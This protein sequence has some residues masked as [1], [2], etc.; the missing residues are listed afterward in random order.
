MSR[1]HL[2]GILAIFCAWPGVVKGQNGGIQCDPPCERGTCLT[3]FRFFTGCICDE[4]FD[5]QSC[6]T[7]IM[8][9]DLECPDNLH[10]PTYHGKNF[11]FVTFEPIRMSDNAGPELELYLSPKS[12]SAFYYGENDVE[13]KAVDNSGNE[14]TCSFTIYVQDEESPV[15]ECPPNITY[16]LGNGE[17]DM[18]VN[19]SA[20]SVTDNVD[21]SV[22]VTSSPR[23]GSEF[24]LGVHLVEMEAVDKSG[25]IGRC[26]FTVTILDLFVCEDGSLLEKDAEC[27]SLWDCP[28]G[29]E[30]YNC[31]P[32]TANET[33][34]H[35][36][37]NQNG[38]WKFRV[39]EGF[40]IH[41]KIRS[42]SYGRVTVGEGNVPWEYILHEDSNLNIIYE[43]SNLTA[44]LDIFL[45]TNTIWMIYQSGSYDDEEDLI[46]IFIDS[47]AITSPIHIE[48][49]NFILRND[50][51]YN[52]LS[53]VYLWR[54]TV[55]VDKWLTG[56]FLE[57]ER[58]VDLLIRKSE[59]HT[60]F[61]LGRSHDFIYP[62]EEIWIK[63]DGIR[64]FSLNLSALT[65]QVIQVP[66]VDKHIVS[67]Y[68]SLTSPCSLENWIIE[69]PQPFQ[70]AMKFLNTNV[71]QR[72]RR[73]LFYEGDLSNMT[74]VGKLFPT[75]DVVENSFVT[76]LTKGMVG[77]VF[78]PLAFCQYE[79]TV[80]NQTFLDL[81]F[82]LENLTVKLE[83][84]EVFQMTSLRESY[85][86]D[87]FFN[88][89]I[90]TSNKELFVEV[91]LPFL[92]CSS[93][94]NGPLAMSFASLESPHPFTSSITTS[95]S[96]DLGVLRTVALDSTIE[97]R[98]PYNI[99]IHSSVP[100]VGYMVCPES[101]VV[102]R[103]DQ[104]C[105]TVLD[106]PTH[107]DEIGCEPTYVDINTTAELLIPAV[108]SQ[109]IIYSFQ[110]NNSDD[111]FLFQYD[112]SRNDIIVVSGS[113]PYLGS[114]SSPSTT[115]QQK[116]I[117][118]K[119]QLI[120]TEN[121]IW[122]KI[123]S[124]AHK[125]VFFGTL[126]VAGV[127][128]Y[129]D[130]GNNL[131]VSN[132]YKCDGLHHCSN[133][134]DETDCAPLLENQGTDLSL[135]TSFQETT[136][137]SFSKET[138]TF[139]EIDLNNYASRS[140]YMAV[141]TGSYYSENSSTIIEWNPHE[142]TD[143]IIITFYDKIWIVMKARFSL[144]SSSP[145]SVTA[146]SVNDY[147]YCGNN[148]VVSI[149]YKCDGLHH[150][151]N[152]FDEKDCSPLLENQE[153]DLSLPTSFQETTVW[154]FSKVAESFFEI[155]LDNYASRSYYMAVGTGSYYSENSSTII[156][157]NPYESTDRII[158]TLYD[159]IWI[160]MKASSSLPSSSPGSVTAHGFNEVNTEITSEASSFVYPT[161]T[162]SNR[163]YHWVYRFPPGMGGKVHCD[164]IALRS[165]QTMEIG[166]VEEN[167]FLPAIVVLRNQYS[168][169]TAEIQIP[170]EV[171]WIKVNYT[172]SS[173]RSYRF[174][175]FVCAVNTTVKL[176][177]GEPSEVVYVGEDDKLIWIGW[178]IQTP[179]M[180][181]TYFA[182]GNEDLSDVTVGVG[183]NVEKNV[184]SDYLFHLSAKTRNF[185]IN[186][187][188]WTYLSTDRCRYRC[189]WSY[190]I[191]AAHLE[192][193]FLCAES[194][195]VLNSTVV[196]DGTPDCPY[197]DDEIGCEIAGD[198]IATFFTTEYPDNIP[199]GR[200]Q[201]WEYHTQK[202]N[203]TVIVHFRELFLGYSDNFYAGVGELSPENSSVNYRPAADCIL[204]RYDP[205]Q[206]LY[207]QSNMIWVVIESSSNSESGK[208]WA[209]VRA[210]H[211]S[212]DIL[213]C[214][215]GRHIAVKDQIC[216]NLWTC[217]NGE[218]EVGCNAVQIFEEDDAFS[219]EFS[220]TI[221]VIESTYSW[222]FASNTNE[223]VFAVTLTTDNLN[224]FQL[225]IG[226]GIDFLDIT[227][228]QKVFYSPHKSD[229]TY[230]LG[231]EIWLLLEGTLANEVINITVVPNSE[232]QVCEGSGTLITSEKICNNNWD[233]ED[234][235]DEFYCEVNVTMDTTLEVSSQ[236]YP[237]R[238]NNVLNR[239][240]IYVFPEG[241]GGLLQCDD[242][243]LAY[244]QTLEFGTGE[245][246]FQLNGT[247]AVLRDHY[248]Y[249]TA[250]IQIPS[251]T[252]WIKF[253]Y[254]SSYSS[255]FY[256][257]H[258]SV[259][260]VDAT[261]TL[262]AGERM[263]ITYRVED[264]EF[265]WIGWNIE[266]PQLY[267]TFFSFEDEDLSQANVGVGINFEENITAAYLRQSSS[268]NSNIVTN[269]SAWTYL[270]TY[271]CS[272]RYSSCYWSYTISAVQPQEL[273]FCEGSSQP[274]HNDDVCNNV[275]DCED[276]SD[277]A[278]CEVNITS[279]E[280]Q[281]VM[282]PNYPLRSSSKL[283]RSW[284]YRF[285]A[286]MGGHLQCD[287]ISLDYGHTLEIGIGDKLFQPDGT[288][289][290][291]RDHYTYDTAEIQIPSEIVWIKF[292]YGTSS[293][294]RY[295]SFHCT[296]S[297]VS[298]TLTVG[299][300][301]SVDI[302]YRA[303]HEE[304]VWIGWNIDTPQLHFTTF[305]FGNEDLSQVTVGVGFDFNSNITAAHL[306]Q[307]SSVNMDITINGSAW[308]YLSTSR[309]NNGRY[310]YYSYY[311]SPC[312]WSY[313]VMAV[314][315]Q[316]RHFCEGSYQLINSDDLCNNAWDCE[317]GYD[318]ANCGVNVTTNGTIPEVSSPGYPIRS[319]DAQDRSWT[320]RFPATM[321]GLIECD[322][323][324]LAY[325]QTLEI[326][327][328]EN[329][330]QMNG[331][332]AV[333]R[334]SFSYDKAEI[335]IP[336]ETVWIKFNYGSRS[337]YRRY[338]SF[339]CS[340]S[341]VNA[342]V[343][344][345]PN[346][347]SEITYVAEDD[348]FVW[349]GWNIQ[350][351][352]T[353][354]TYLSVGDEDLSVITIGLGS[355]FGRNV[356]ADYILQS[357][358][359][360]QDLA[361]TGLT[362][363]YLST[364]RC[365]LYRCE[366]SYFVSAVN[367]A[368][369]FSCRES[370]VLLKT[371]LLCN[372]VPNC[373]Y[374]DDEI[375]CE[376]TEDEFVTLFSTGYPD[377]RPS[378]IMQKWEYHTKEENVTMIVH[379]RELFLG[380]SDTFY[381]GVGELSPEDSSVDYRPAQ[382]CILTRYDPIQDLYLQSNMIWIVI[383]S[384]SLSGSGKLWAEIRVVK[385]NEEILR[386]NDA[387]H[388]AANDQIC[389][390]LWT[391]EGGEDEI[392][393]DATILS[394]WETFSIEFENT[395]ESPDSN[396][397]SWSFASN[398]TESA[399]TIS[400]V[401]NRFSDLQLTIG[402]G[403]NVL[404]TTSVLRV[405]R[406]SQNLHVTYALSR[407]MWIRL[408]GMPTYETINITVIPISELYFCEGSE[409][410][411]SRDKLCD[412]AW[413]CDSGSDESF[414]ELN[415]TAGET[416][417]VFSPE[418]PLRT[419]DNRTRSWRYR[420]PDGMGGLVHCDD[421][422]LAYGQSL[423]IG[424]GERFL[425]SDGTVIELRDHYSYNT[426]KIQIPSESVWI[427]FNYGTSYYSRYYR[428][429]CSVSAVSST[430]SLELEETFEITYEAQNDEYV[431]IG[432]S[433]QVPEPLS[434]FFELDNKDLSDVTV[435][436]GIDFE[437]NI[438]ANHLFQASSY[439]RDLL[440]NGS[441]WTFL[442]T[443]SC[444]TYKCEWSYT[445]GA[446]NAKELYRCEEYDR[447][448]IPTSLCDGIWDCESGSDEYGCS[449]NILNE[450][451]NYGF[452]LS[453]PYRHNAT[454]SWIFDVP[455]GMEASLQ[456]RAVTMHRA[457]I[458]I[459]SGSNSSDLKTR[460][461]ASIDDVEKL[462]LTI[463]A[464]QLWIKTVVTE[465][466]FILE[467]LVEI[468]PVLPQDGLCSDDEFRCLYTRECIE[469][470][471]MCDGNFDCGDRSDESICDCFSPTEVRNGVGECVP[472]WSLCGG[473]SYITGA[474]SVDEMIN[475]D[476]HCTTRQPGLTVV[477]N[478]FICDG[479]YDCV[480][481]ADER[482][483]NCGC[484]LPAFSCGEKCLL[485]N[486]VCNGVIDCEDGE[487]E[488]DC[489]CS[490]FE[491]SCA[492]DCFAYWDGC[493]QERCMDIE[494]CRACPP[495]FFQCKDYTCLPAEN[496]CD[497]VGDC[498]DA[499]DEEGCSFTDVRT[500]R[501]VGGSRQNEGRVEVF[502]DGEWGTVC[503]DWWGYS[504]AAV[505]CRQLGFGD[506][507]IAYSYARFGRGEGP[508]WLDNVACTGSELRLED[509]LSNGWGI[510]NC[511]H[512]SD[513]G[514]RC[515]LDMPTVRLADGSSAYEG[516][517]EVFYQGVWG[518]VCDDDWDD[519]DATVI[520]RHLGLGDS[521]QAITFAEFGRGIGPIWMDNVNCEGHEDDIE[522]CSSNGWGDHNCGHHEDAGVICTHELTTPQDDQLSTSFT[523]LSTVQKDNQVLTDFVEV[524]TVQ[525][526]KQE[527]EF[528]TVLIGETSFPN[529]TDKTEVLDTA[530]L[531]VSTLQPD[532]QSPTDSTERSDVFT[533]EIDN[534]ASTDFKVFL[535]ETSVPIVEDETG[536]ANT[537]SPNTEDP[538]SIATQRYSDDF[539]TTEIPQMIPDTPVTILSPGYPTSLPKFTNGTWMISAPP[540][541]GIQVEVLDV[542]IGHLS[543]L[544]LGVG[545]VVDRNVIAE[546]NEYSGPV[547]HTFLLRSSNIWLK[548]LSRYRTTTKRGFFLKVTPVDGIGIRE[549]FSLMENKTIT[550]EST[551]YPGNYPVMVDD[552]WNFEVAENV[553]FTVKFVDISLE[554]NWD[555]LSVGP[556]KE[557]SFSL[558]LLKVTGET[559]PNDQVLNTRNM[560][561]RFTSDLSN[562]SRGF[563]L[564][565][566]ATGLM[567][568]PTGPTDA[569]ASADPTGSPT[570]APP[571]ANAP[572]SPTD[573]P[574]TA[575]APGI[576][577]V[578]GNSENE[579][580]V[581][582]YHNGIWG[583]VCDDSWDDNDAAVVC[584]ELG[585]EGNAE[586]VSFAEF[587]QGTGQIWLD[588][589]FCIG[590][591]SRLEDCG[592]AG[593][594]IHNC[595]HSED[596][597]V[598]CQD[599][600]DASPFTI[601]EGAIRIVGGSSSYEGRVEIFHNGIWGTICDDLWSSNDAQ[602]VCRQLG[603]TGSG[604]TRTSGFTNGYGQIW[605]T[606]VG[607]RGSET[608]LEYCSK[609]DW[610][611]NSCYH[612]ED[613]GVRCYGEIGATSNLPRAVRLVGGSDENEGRVEIF[614]NGV[615]GT[616]CDDY[617][618]SYD[619][620]VVCKQLGYGNNGEAVNFARFGRGT[621]PI[622]LDDVSCTGY[623]TRLEDCGSRG[624]G[625]HN[626]D[627][628]DDA[629]VR[630]EGGDYN[631]T[632]NSSRT[633]SYNR[634][635]SGYVEVNWNF[636]APENN[637]I[638]ISLS[639]VDIDDSE[640]EILAYLPGKTDAL[641]ITRYGV[642]SSPNVQHVKASR[643]TM[644]YTSAY[645]S[646][647]DSFT[648]ILTAVP[649]E[650][651]QCDGAE[652]PL[653]VRCDGRID[654]SEGIDELN[655]TFDRAYNE[656]EGSI[657]SDYLVKING[658]RGMT[659]GGTLINSR[660][661]LT[662]AGC[663]T[664]H[665]TSEYEVVVGVN[666][667]PRTVPENETYSVI[668]EVDISSQS[669]NE[670]GLA[671]LKLDRPVEGFGTNV[672]P[673][674][675]P[676]S[677]RNVDPGTYVNIVGWYSASPGDDVEALVTV[678]REPVV[679]EDFCMSRRYPSFSAGGVFCT[680]Y[681]QSYGADCFNIYGGPVVHDRGDGRGQEI[682]GVVV[683]QATSWEC[684]QLFAPK[685][686][687]LVSSQVDCIK[688]I[689]SNV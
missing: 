158:F 91:N 487:D 443:Y 508:I 135:P 214:T 515:E 373:P 160:V 209:E 184:T 599:M 60:L 412:Y 210:V 136:V 494:V 201:K 203:V 607:C 479:F 405:F 331:T 454:Y 447:V 43:D 401:G 153:I 400:P 631:L 445:I 344:L 419:S 98:C 204:T 655:C 559:I 155:N 233:C 365:Y 343:T 19:F 303:E 342:T 275:W 499:E 281:E 461:F 29:E 619:A 228:V 143:R 629:G 554:N 621:G 142:S 249:D 104:T 337:S 78:F 444:N 463:P 582:I 114:R 88:R 425:Q 276:G 298:T 396:E 260:A 54:V 256:S 539:M 534:R 310:G 308:T 295:Y 567:T 470:N 21:Q 346:E 119:K 241:M 297:A 684:G 309:C 85:T 586:A 243:S 84:G 521:G 215:D 131:A 50:N 439:V 265:V 222:T 500:V 393:C 69:L 325:G 94:Y 377:N 261:L 349:I 614:Y 305:S 322:H 87:L 618:S 217:D 593:W 625:V 66:E 123:M 283:T 503:D 103:E 14:A 450:R 382:D 360:I 348:E 648:A 685:M 208:M 179:E 258:C 230:I 408:R 589:V 2:L 668:A 667:F 670:S 25:N 436:V 118:S 282:S 512:Y 44:G 654:C 475:C 97:T 57:Y 280:T 569:P 18:V 333:L 277:E 347:T 378:Y 238:S 440:L 501:L 113:G 598:R 96:E 514:V 167:N 574:P 546:I 399:F 477:S 235:S 662:A 86:D 565:V 613:A 550:I 330:F 576:R 132:E 63:S 553:A 645:S 672:F 529:V 540:G 435:G 366:W 58:D 5:G 580:R 390:N 626:C 496:V 211:I 67:I 459:G 116:D 226:T 22:T 404:D 187:S 61:N 545:T 242:I 681:I 62:V 359:Y 678:R 472:R 367:T 531:E 192:D 341:A 460:L 513:A 653:D 321:G 465:G 107:E 328:G 370:S 491:I 577:L 216:D 286:G 555:Y 313:S 644:T 517:V 516:R 687:P 39:T 75:Q 316:G 549:T 395:L 449:P 590:T 122:L 202:E 632:S 288:V 601:E 624:W 178:D 680:G 20:V 537:N 488:L 307:S 357:G 35:H 350:T 137:W 635:S 301:E 302:T 363:T 634:R 442:S 585:F 166:T 403:T 257:F 544:Q 312:Y 525:S 368:D 220:N 485:P 150:C 152:G 676:Q 456:L 221:E 169:D 188:A 640:L 478:K 73:L 612:Y 420:F 541:Y 532:N 245:N 146:Y 658:S 584:R 340:V 117:S 161:Y 48:D 336:S 639:S 121:I 306:R 250:E 596:A 193:F 23:S 674:S 451:D 182:F 362:W 520:C 530:S 652:L 481:G 642:S 372:G 406:P 31:D 223:S 89:R 264:D 314:N 417:E 519:D 95:S 688:D 191:T 474:A 570:D 571:T 173:Y 484:K 522:L 604:Y 125:F 600:D 263:D 115:F 76:H 527:P 605:L 147:I 190:T 317:N 32:E 284:L 126:S 47:T 414:C 145:G 270:S 80:L 611:D 299:S 663:L 666:D 163:G 387:R 557:P 402:T 524:S 236:D 657:F 269:G 551:N 159:E 353:F 535:G 438:T 398:A 510:H 352:E 426:A 650:A 351:P 12:G 675:L 610:G 423:Q 186:G 379:F 248:S 418:Y 682:I 40:G 81:E 566:T 369:F 415:V 194:P 646:Y 407:E 493:M 218:D 37:S 64:E 523:E 339:H 93:F 327:T 294:T 689:I 138:E 92:T 239:S 272:N 383:A 51:L 55:P 15:V 562:T 247:I 356:T 471:Q 28:N 326:G 421:I 410:L 278:Y 106:C 409:Q 170:S 502:H 581:E 111:Y 109:D 291:L 627:H 129:I 134:F 686:Y 149:E 468:K 388:I 536:V 462:D 112:G 345:G 542:H 649:D 267:G 70:F 683:E 651:K 231:K 469:S 292:S 254:G 38:T 176:I 473:Y 430:I 8:P 289:T 677:G 424:G 30:E 185:G 628:F 271:S 552:V 189:E 573:A 385:E 669:R 68:P 583:T 101:S 615:W 83:K 453:R 633:I 154:T 10:E 448:V 285:P 207:L 547:N 630:C 206:D 507:G 196:C 455:E 79:D 177:P 253:T 489:E 643:V 679:S 636:V 332:V 609:S 464:R 200:M 56:S 59:D 183:T 315:P 490:S 506:S 225:T 273:F 495:N 42:S 386:C 232:L 334:N 656:T 671:L 497:N 324:S 364:Y 673:L 578:G 323:I 458:S 268:D 564:N 266:T 4:G 205:I 428:F 509:C 376:I 100:N 641:L 427:K 480:D 452:S 65:P 466:P 171:V 120:F 130:C 416:V 603:F 7:D 53:S 434:T 304:F 33:T 168:Y 528:F 384:D 128:E 27:N 287:V 320:F 300:D 374:G 259:S 397:Y 595:G 296:V 394:M 335:Q 199:A 251:Q 151:S 311:Y 279:G 597:G 526:D 105:D 504:D 543:D 375:G 568:P 664:A 482:V 594:G 441:A 563:R 172:Y 486:E 329:M 647:G 82:K 175:C 1:L 558:T 661:I 180:F 592:S 665:A 219:I 431:W 224:T 72:G 492:E 637:T 234:G 433:I 49:E 244:G 358:D 141:G 638:H 602:V 371:N 77:I 591:E 338:Y 24:S 9:P 392:R 411:T 457:Q 391:C 556:G 227:S 11:T 46:E 165:G 620:K 36:S 45:P 518:T 162:S 290:E 548:F 616:V 579:G 124:S 255:R 174:H 659:C 623:E 293:Y 446:V 381:A 617:W 198:E 110:K 319:Y 511:G 246:L 156:E 13:M 262:G 6:D 560:W 213:R 181:G 622:W 197:G 498:T 144:P 380:Y 52:N 108:T 252:V 16:N 587:G 476:F 164:D 41:I 195:T 533:V 90:F 26:T 157:W 361:L 575:N 354:G 3:F 140:Y 588:N 102:V 483:E 148:S 74:P 467:G 229:V 237:I 133:G 413:D 17:L 355:D 127:T 99:K 608:R 660:W 212:D 606:N 538:T 389:D 318:E 274:V 437:K 572:G 429:H 561:I 34:L 240:W 71:I 422:S 139:F 432:W 505:V